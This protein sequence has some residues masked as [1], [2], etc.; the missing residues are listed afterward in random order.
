MTRRDFHLFLL[1]LCLMT[2][3]FGEPLDSRGP[4][5]VS[6]AQISDAQRILVANGYLQAGGYRSA[7]LDSH[8]SAAVKDFQ[9]AHFLPVD[10]DLDP[11]TIGMLTS[12]RP[13]A[14]LAQARPAR[15]A[16]GAEAMT[17][18][19]AAADQ[20]Q[21]AQAERTGTQDRVSGAGASRKM[22]ATASSIP[23]FAGL[24]GL[25]LIAGV[26]L[27]RRRRA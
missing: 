15:L 21:P 3:L 20:S 22:P 4:H 16:Y 24:G 23:F 27:L 9:R 11:D 10:G 14:V 7:V 25:L 17:P 19:T 6:G 1:C 18:G 12:H 5:F 26:A 13:R 2:P 8:T